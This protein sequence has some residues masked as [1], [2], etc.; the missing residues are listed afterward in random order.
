MIRVILLLASTLDT[1]WAFGPPEEGKYMVWAGTLVRY[2]W[3]VHTAVTIDHARLTWVLA[4]KCEWRGAVF[5][6]EGKFDWT[7][8]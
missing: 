5:Y 1:L 8:G 2:S 6:R 3:G 7:N 4:L